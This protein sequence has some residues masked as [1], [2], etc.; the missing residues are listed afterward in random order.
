[1]IIFNWLLAREYKSGNLQYQPILDPIEKRSLGAFRHV[2]MDG[3]IHHR[4]GSLNLGFGYVLEVKS[5][6]GQKNEITIPIAIKNNIFTRVVNDTLYISFYKEVVDVRSINSIPKSQGW[7]NASLS[8]V[9]I[10]SLTLNH[11]SFLINGLIT[12]SLQ[13]RAEDAEINV[14][15][16]TAKRLNAIVRGASII[17]IHASNT[18]EGCEYSITDEEGTIEIDNHA[19]KTYIQGFIHPKARIVLSGDASEMQGHLKK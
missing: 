19:A 7:Y 9:K 10:N 11:G 1:M 4:D 16:L 6:P 17:R 2:V 15:N 18:I 14:S 12:D 13:F 3:R 5:T 8:A